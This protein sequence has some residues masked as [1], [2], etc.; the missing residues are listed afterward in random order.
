MYI[1]QIA[2]SLPDLPNV[3]RKRLR[4]RYGLHHQDIDALLSADAGK[5]V[6]YDGEVGYSAVRYFETV[7]EGRDPKGVVN[8]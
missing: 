4:E 2:A 3:S 5:D 7:A 6:P 8:W 1:K